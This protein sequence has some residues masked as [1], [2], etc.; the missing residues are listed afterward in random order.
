MARFDAFSRDERVIIK[1]ALQARRDALAKAA[2]PENPWQ[3]PDAVAERAA[4]ASMVHELEAVEMAEEWW[5][6]YSSN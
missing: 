3:D 1:A 6:G 2:N 4:L 5:Y